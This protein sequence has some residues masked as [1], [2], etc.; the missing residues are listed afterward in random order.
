MRSW[1]TLSVCPSVCL[2]FRGVVSKPQTLEGLIGSI[3]ALI[4]VTSPSKASKVNPVIGGVKMHVVRRI[5]KLQRVQINAAGTV[6]QSSR[7]YDKPILHQLH[8]LLV[9]QRI[10]VGSSGVGSLEHVHSG[11]HPA[12]PNHERKTETEKQRERQKNLWCIMGE[13]ILLQ[14]SKN[15]QKCCLTFL[16]FS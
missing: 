16:R 2:T 10:Q 11:L 6:L 3:I 5:Q 7:S 8:W 4:R 12:R 9:Q 1:F 15:V 14:S 13:A